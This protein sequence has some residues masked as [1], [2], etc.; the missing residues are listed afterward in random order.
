MA[1]IRKRVWKSRGVE[2]SAWVVDYFD[3]TSSGQRRLKTF[4]TKKEAEHWATTAL[5]EVQQGIHTPSGSSLTVAKAM[6]L[7]IEHCEA[8]KLEKSTLRQRRQ[9]ARLHIKPFLGEVKLA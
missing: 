8:E 5:Y 6:D 9:H 1:S 7:W 4:A 3:R 2:R